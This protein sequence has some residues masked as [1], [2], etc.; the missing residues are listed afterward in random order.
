MNCSKGDRN[1]NKLAVINE[2]QPK[3]VKSV[4]V[5]EMVGFAAEFGDKYGPWIHVRY[6]KK[7]FRNIKPRLVNQQMHSNN[8]SKEVKAISKDDAIKELNDVVNYVP[9][10]ENQKFSGKEISDAGILKDNKEIQVLQLN[11]DPDGMAKNEEIGN[12]KSIDK[13]V[14]DGAIKPSIKISLEPIADMVLNSANSIVNKN[15]F[16]ILN[17]SMEEG[18]I[19]VVDKYGGNELLTSN[20][21]SETAKVLNDSNLDGCSSTSRKKPKGESE[22]DQNDSLTGQSAGP[23]P[24]SQVHKQVQVL[25]LLPQYPH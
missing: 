5:N 11:G 1:I 6:G 2:D 3:E 18:Q 22:F 15:R 24:K 12:K 21:G 19:L 8:A 13:I 4:A 23:S 20:A 16:D 7:S 9:E 10:I 17:S 14:T 25:P